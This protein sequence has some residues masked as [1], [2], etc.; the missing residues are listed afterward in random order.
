MVFS[1][2][3][4]EFSAAS[5]HTVTSLA[6]WFSRMEF[7]E[8]YFDKIQPSSCVFIDRSEGFDNFVVVYYNNNR[9][10]CQGLNILF[11]YLLNCLLVQCFL[12][13]DLDGST[14]SLSARRSGPP[15]NTTTYM[16][17]T[18]LSMLLFSFS[19]V[20]AKWICLGK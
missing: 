5:M 19:H 3:P 17:S 13:A 11:F 18:Y 12:F 10:Y 16:V 1:M 8:D 2:R 4:Q 15:E 6:I 9:F 14:N 7:V 20:G